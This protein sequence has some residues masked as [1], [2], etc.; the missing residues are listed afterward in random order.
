MAN[1]FDEEEDEEEEQ[2]DIFGDL[3]DEEIEETND[4]VELATIGIMPKYGKEWKKINPTKSIFYHKELTKQFFEWYLRNAESKELQYIEVLQLPNLEFRDL[5]TATI[6][7]KKEKGEKRRKKERTT[8]EIVKHAMDTLEEVKEKPIAEVIT[9]K[10]AEK[11]ITMLLDGSVIVREEIDGVLQTAH[12]ISIEKCMNCGESRLCSPETACCLICDNVISAK[13]YETLMKKYGNKITKD[14]REKVKEKKESL[15]GLISEEGAIELVQKDLGIDER[16][17]KVKDKPKKKL[18]DK[19]IDDKKMFDEEPQEKKPKKKKVIEESTPIS[20]TIQ[21]PL[22]PIKIADNKIKEFNLE[23]SEKYILEQIRL[24]NFTIQ[25]VVIDSDFYRGS[26]KK[27]GVRKLQLALN[28]STIITDEKYWQKDNKAEEWVAKYK[29]KA[30]APSGRY[31]EAVG[32]CEQFEKNNVRTFHD[33]LA[34]A[35]TRATS[36]AVLDL[37]GWGAISTSEIDDTKDSDN[38]MFD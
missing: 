28:I 12:Y 2:K 35:Q 18:S 37:V 11:D 34:T 27:S 16:V 6:K 5:L 19:F 17:N 24:Y 26:L 1:M 9:S 32:S 7:K 15:K 4:E 3:T 10:K 31:A 30:I 13:N 29:V 23:D 14:F 33:T 38:N 20:D 25:N 8:E 36:R 21:T 22:V